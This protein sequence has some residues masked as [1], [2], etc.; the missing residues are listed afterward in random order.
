MLTKRELYM[1]EASSIGQRQTRQREAILRCIEQAEGPLPIPE[2]Y[3]R[4]RKSLA[5]L[6]I[7]TVY[8]TLK[9]LNEAGKSACNL[10]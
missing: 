3:D 7:A 4:A 6:G 1:A 9:L 5:V 10:A 8:R 2:I